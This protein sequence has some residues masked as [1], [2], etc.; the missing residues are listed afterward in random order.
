M[1]M[2]AKLKPRRMILVRQ[3]DQQHCQANDG[4]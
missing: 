2:I 1:N 3:T 4:F